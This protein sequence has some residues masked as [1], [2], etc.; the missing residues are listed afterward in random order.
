MLFG[1]AINSLSLNV[2][3]NLL[4]AHSYISHLTTLYTKCFSYPHFSPESYLI[5]HL[6]RFMFHWI[7]IEL[8]N[9]SLYCV[10]N[11][12]RF[13]ERPRGTRCLGLPEVVSW[14]PSRAKLIKLV[15]FDGPRGIL[16]TCQL[17][18]LR[19]QLV[20]QL[21]TILSGL[22]DLVKLSSTCHP[23]PTL[24]LP[25]TGAQTFSFNYRRNMRTKF[26]YSIVYVVSIQQYSNAPPPKTHI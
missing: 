26:T 5:V 3:I 17:V 8:S 15:C 1:N 9:K 12:A 11:K 25:K 6:S 2:Y 19:D 16:D 20:N 23:S 7:L 14:S 4:S 22:G 18:R 10:M 21:N 24:V 13:N